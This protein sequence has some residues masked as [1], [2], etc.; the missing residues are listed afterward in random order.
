MNF[1][2]LSKHGQRFLLETSLQCE[3]ASVLRFKS[4]Q[5]IE[6]ATLDNIHNFMPKQLIAEPQKERLAQLPKMK[7]IESQ[8]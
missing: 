2:H 6:D 4:L 7:I 1:I 5:L 8:L 3:F